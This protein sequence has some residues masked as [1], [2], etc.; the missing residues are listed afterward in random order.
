M[1]AVLSKVAGCH[2]PR[3]GQKVND[4][5]QLEENSGRKGD[6]SNCAYIGPQSDLVGHHLA[7][8]ITAKK[9]DRHWS[10]YEIAKED[11]EDKKKTPD[12]KNPLGRA[13]LLRLE[14]GRQK[15]PHLLQ[16]IRERNDDA[17]DDGDQ[18][19]S[20]ELPGHLKVDQGKVG[21]LDAQTLPYSHP[22]RKRTQ[23]AEGRKIILLWTKKDFLKDQFLEKEG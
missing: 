6:E 1:F 19:M 11:A 20:G 8:L 10:H 3:N 14:A 5:G 2:D 13:A 4:D 12:P 23:K 17:A 9:A 18:D 22:A 21:S 16:E 7:H 15:P